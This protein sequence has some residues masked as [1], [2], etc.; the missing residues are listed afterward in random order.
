[1]MDLIDIVVKS[2][3]EA[4]VFTSLAGGAILIGLVGSVYF[5]FK[6]EKDGK[7][8]LREQAQKEKKIQYN[9]NYNA[10]D[11]YFK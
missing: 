8:M 11:N 4:P 7:K 1:M 5:Y 6:G 9:T 10:I 2:F 3:K